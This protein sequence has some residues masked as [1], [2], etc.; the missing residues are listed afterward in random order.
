MIVPSNPAVPSKDWIPSQLASSGAS[1]GSPRL[2]PVLWE[3]EGR[4]ITETL[5]PEGDAPHAQWM[6]SNFLP[7]R[8][9]PELIS[10][11]PSFLGPCLPHA[12]LGRWDIC[13][14]SSPLCHW[15][16][17]FGASHV[18]SLGRGSLRSLDCDLKVPF[19]VLKYLDSGKSQISKPWYIEE[20]FS[21][22]TDLG[23]GVWLTLCC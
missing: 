3:A 9:F 7:W 15:P 21:L 19:T 16:C 8:P 23:G 13:L 5:S 2:V 6:W 1:S 20:L 12:A 4:A 17:A 10:S 14:W 11:L 18:D 22:S